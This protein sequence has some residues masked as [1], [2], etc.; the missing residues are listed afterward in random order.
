MAKRRRFGDIMPFRCRPLDRLR[1]RLHRATPPDRRPF[2]GCQERSPSALVR[3]TFRPRR[4]G[5]EGKSAL[6]AGGETPKPKRSDRL[7]RERH[8]PQLATPPDHLRPVA[9]LEATRRPVRVAE[10]GLG[11]A[12]PR[13]RT[14]SAAPARACGSG[15]RTATW[16]S[17]RCGSQRAARRQSRIG[18][19]DLR[20]R[21]GNDRKGGIGAVRGCGRAEGGMR[22]ARPTG[23]GKGVG[24]HTD[25]ISFWGAVHHAR[26]NCD[27]DGNLACGHSARNLYPTPASVM[28]CR[29]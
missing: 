14:D 16:A 1:K 21:P 25:W 24:S 20:R 15:P 2:R 13:L 4:L 12:L 11:G 27:A 22:G 6:R 18:T 17:P 19:S 3:G 10:A 5:L 8:P 23:N 7:F 28:R 29:G 9:P 26:V